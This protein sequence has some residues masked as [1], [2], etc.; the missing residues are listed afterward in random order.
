MLLPPTVLIFCINIW[1]L[2]FEDWG[3]FVNNLMFTQMIFYSLY[4]YVVKKK[5]DKEVVTFPQVVY[6]GENLGG[7]VE[8]ARYF[9]SKGMV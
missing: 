7:L 2:K 1:N 4:P 6:N 5:L 3:H 8:A 9:K